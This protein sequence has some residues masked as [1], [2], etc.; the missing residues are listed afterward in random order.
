M[1]ERSGVTPEMLRAAG[2]NQA[3]GAMKNLIDDGLIDVSEAGLRR[4]TAAARAEASMPRTPSIAE[5][6]AQGEANI[7]AMQELARRAQQ[8][9]ARTVFNR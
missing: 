5:A 2:K 3:A 7:A 6:R 4:A 8:P 1:R 9:G